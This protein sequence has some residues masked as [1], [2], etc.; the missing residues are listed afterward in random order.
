MEMGSFRNLR[1]PL[2][3]GTVFLA[4]GLPAD[5][6]VTS[7]L[8]ALRTKPCEFGV[9]YAGTISP[10]APYRYEVETDNANRVVRVTRYQRG[11]ARW[12]TRITFNTANVPIATVTSAD[13]APTGRESIE[14]DASGCIVREVSY[15]MSGVRTSSVT[16]TYTTEYV[17]YRRFSA[18]DEPVSID[19]LYYNAEGLL[20]RDVAY[21]DARN[22]SHWL[23]ETYDPST[24]NMTEVL[25][26]ED[27]GRTLFSRQVFQYDSNDLLVHADGFKANGTLF[28]TRDFDDGNLVKLNYNLTGRVITFTNDANG[29]ITAAEQRDHGVLHCRFAIEHLADN[30]VKRTVV[31]AAD[32]SLLAE[33]PNHSVLECRSN[34]TVVGE[35]QGTIYKQP[36]WWGP[37]AGK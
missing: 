31:R 7:Y 5:A 18:A 32:G 19:R 25:Q 11:R 28:A 1:A 26:Y 3:A 14:R 15:A 16:Y 8:H 33:Y 30:T 22:L 21:D 23:D 27:D 9:R 37:S 36:P 17:E 10:T 35:Y 24:G 6:A 12:E 4:Y 20:V 29:N 2:M 34:G 13:G